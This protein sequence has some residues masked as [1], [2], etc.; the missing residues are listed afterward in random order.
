VPFTGPEGSIPS[1]QQPATDP[2]SES[3]ES[4]PHHNDV[5]N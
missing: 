4:I 1:L 2:Y 5:F 3:D